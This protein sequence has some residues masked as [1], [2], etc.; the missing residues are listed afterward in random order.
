MDAFAQAGLPGGDLLAGGE[1]IEGRTGKAVARL[2][3]RHRLDRDPGLAGIADL[4]AG[5]RI[6]RGEGGDCDCREQHH[7]PPPAMLAPP[8]RAN[9]AHAAARQPGAEIPGPGLIGQGK[10]LGHSVAFLLRAFRA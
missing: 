2:F 3:E 6:G 8:L 7:R 10:F 4:E 9:A 5:Q 1:V